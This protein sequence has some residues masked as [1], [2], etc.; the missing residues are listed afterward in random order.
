MKPELIN[1]WFPL[2]RQQQY[3]SR[4]R[5]RVGLPRR[6]AECF[7]RLW[8]YL[9]VK[10]KQAEGEML[11]PP[12]TDLAPI[13]RPIP[14]THR[15]AAALFYSETERGGDR[16]AG[17]MIDRLA[18]LGLLE[19]K[20]DGQ[21]TCIR[22]RA[23]PEIT[24]AE[25]ATSAPELVADAF[26][27]RTDTI[28]IANLL[29]RSFIWMERDPS[30]VAPH[31]LS[32]ILRLW[33][34]QYPRGMRVLRRCDNENAVAICILSPIASGSEIN[35]FLPPTKSLFLTGQAE[36]D[37]F[38]IAPPGDLSCTAAFARIWMIE[39]P[40]L[41]RHQIYQSLEDCRQT[42]IAMQ[43][44]F[45]NLC[46]FYGVAIHPL[47]EELLAAIGFQKIAQCPQTLMYWAYQA[48]DHFIQLDIQQAIA[49]LNLESFPHDA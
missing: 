29:A 16:A 1:Q 8:A 37:P 28:P 9:L 7:V 34:Q 38:A 10:Q 44:D 24:E 39:Q 48:V 31:K 25:L 23:V 5:G 11:Q 42:L 43:A 13:E 32:K 45:P 6:R 21:T 20:F 46:D 12:L 26:N 47:Y 17:M 4:L 14:C 36:V 3:I 33:A 30:V 41:K 22:V 19:K 40:F 27:P 2:S 18:A 15:E 35:F 49:G